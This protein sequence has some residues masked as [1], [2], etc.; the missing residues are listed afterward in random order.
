MQKRKSDLLRE[1][2]R[3]LLWEDLCQHFRDMELAYLCWK[4]RQTAKTLEKRGML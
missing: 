3:K 1:V 2:E 4:N